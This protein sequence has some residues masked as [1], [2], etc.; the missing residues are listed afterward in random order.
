MSKISTNIII[1]IIFFKQMLE[2]IN[3]LLKFNNEMVNKYVI[4]MSNTHN[5]SFRLVNNLITLGTI[6]NLLWVIITY[7]RMPH[8]PWYIFSYIYPKPWYWLVPGII[9]TYCLYGQVM[10]SHLLG[11]WMIVEHT[12]TLQFWLSEIQ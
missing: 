7:L 10:T 12:S 6:S 11:I 4:N 2:Y 9:Q 3:T 1:K 8:S 5:Y